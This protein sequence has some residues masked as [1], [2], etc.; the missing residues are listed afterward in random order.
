LRLSRIA[1]C[2]SSSRSEAS[3]SMSLLALRVLPRLSSSEIVTMVCNIICSFQCSRPTPDSSAKSTDSYASAS[4]GIVD[5]ACKSLVEANGSYS[6]SSESRAQQLTLSAQNHGSMCHQT[7]SSSFLP[8]RRTGVMGPGI[9]GR[10]LPNRRRTLG[11]V[12]RWIPGQRGAPN[13]GF[14]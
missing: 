2:I 14:W 5:S 6:R 8:R 13:D 3:S 12:S 4:P 7:H 1:F 9:S 11:S 10:A